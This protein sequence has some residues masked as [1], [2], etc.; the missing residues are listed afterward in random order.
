[1]SAHGGAG[2]CLTDTSQR[3]YTTEGCEKGGST[4]PRRSAGGLITKSLIRTKA[5]KWHLAKV[6]SVYLIRGWIIL[7]V[8]LWCHQQRMQEASVS[9]LCRIYAH[10]HSAEATCY[11]LAAGNKDHPW[12]AILRLPAGWRQPEC[13]AD[14]PSAPKRVKHR[15]RL[16]YSDQSK[17]CVF[18]LS[19]RDVRVGRTQQTEK[20]DPSP[21]LLWISDTFQS[22]RLRLVCVLMSHLSRMVSMVPVLLDE[23]CSK[24]S[25][26][27]C[28][29]L[30][31]RLCRVWWTRQTRRGRTRVQSIK[32][33]RLPFVSMRRSCGSKQSQQPK[34]KTK[35]KII[36]SWN[37]IEIMLVKKEQKGTLASP[38]FLRFGVDV[39]DGDRLAPLIRSLSKKVAD[40]LKENIR[41]QN[42]ISEPLH[43]NLRITAEQPELIKAN[44]EMDVQNGL[45]KN[46]GSR[47]RVR[48]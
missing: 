11:H 38:E 44:L 23:T 6:H 31:P 24:A 35:I 3:Y 2:W 34:L 8:S 29:L 22:F 32:V 36:Y 43:G 14:E 12:N 20:V 42:C 9:L 39:T 40:A 28:S 7:K 37:N 21:V 30:V 27:S 1:M 4:S 25:A 10:L 45:S 16:F 46:T 47:R 19:P 5:L 33:L 15:N 17:F 41:R 18:H 26:G 13:F 48:H